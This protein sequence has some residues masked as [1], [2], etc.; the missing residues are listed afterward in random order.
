MLSR[1]GGVVRAVASIGESLAVVEPMNPRRFADRRRQRQTT[2]IE[3]D[4]RGY[5]ERFLK[6]ISRKLW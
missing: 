2:M 1:N 4:E 5:F 6:K 3:D